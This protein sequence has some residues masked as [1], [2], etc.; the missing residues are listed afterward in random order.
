MGDL[1]IVVY[2][3]ERRAADVLN[4]LRRG[5]PRLA[6]LENAAYVERDP[7]G[8]TRLHQSSHLT[9]RGPLPRAWTSLVRQLIASADADPSASLR[10][11]DFGID[12]AFSQQVSA[13][14]APGHSALFAVLTETSASDVRSAMALYGGTEFEVSLSRTGA[15]WLCRS[16][17]AGPETQSSPPVPARR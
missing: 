10:P 4:A 13:A 3:S 5:H 14:V 17:Q 16:F 12:D 15:A 6:E 1:L 7:A 11:V 2:E 8:V 9:P